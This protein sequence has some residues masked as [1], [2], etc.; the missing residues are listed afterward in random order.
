MEPLII[1]ATTPHGVVLSRPWGIALDGLLASV[2]WHRDKWAARA[3][4]NWITYHHDQVPELYELPLARCGDPDHDPDW[5]WLATFADLHPHLG[6]DDRPDVR[7]RTGR[8]DRRRL[9]HLSAS[10]S[11]RSVSS[12]S[13]RYQH[14]TIPVTAHPAAAATWRAVG[15]PDAIRDL[16]DELPSIGKHRGVGEGVVTRWEVTSAPGV[17]PWEAGHTHEPGI[18]GRTAPARCLAHHPDISTGPAGN[19]AIRPPYLHAESRTPA[20]HPAR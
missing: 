19:A 5:H 1:T 6:A 18:L 3:A 7:W 13:G 10:I 16:L 14:R 11:A 2:L 8:T 12:Y 17:D 20:Y 15:D 9:Q 4:G